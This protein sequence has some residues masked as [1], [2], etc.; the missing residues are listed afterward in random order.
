MTDT[1]SV[2]ELVRAIPQNANNVSIV[3]CPYPL[4]S[5]KSK[6]TFVANWAEQL[7]EV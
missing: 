3:T 6:G 5:S 2:I 7:N 4:Y 1:K